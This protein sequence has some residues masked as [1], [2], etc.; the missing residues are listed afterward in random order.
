[1][2]KTSEKKWWVQTQ[3]TSELYETEA[4]ARKAYDG[5]KERNQSCYIKDVYPEKCDECGDVDAPA[6]MND[7]D[8]KRIC[9]YCAE[10]HEDL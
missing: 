10:N 9:N 3:W 8:G 2:K 1:M 5:L 4:E 6:R 7:Y